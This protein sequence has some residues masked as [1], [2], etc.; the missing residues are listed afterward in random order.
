[1]IIGQGLR[2][3]IAGVAI[4]VIIALVLGRLVSSFS[5]L[6]YGVRVSSPVILAG[7]SSALLIVAA[8]A[9]YLPARRAASV[10]PMKALRT[11]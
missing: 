2:L 8:M 11:E 5:Q 6:L 4:G 3:A 9:C 10:E 7:I 1:M